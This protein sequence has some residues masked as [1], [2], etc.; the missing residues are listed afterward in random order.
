[1][2]KKKEDKAKKVAKDIV[3]GIGMAYIAGATGEHFD[4]TRTILSNPIAGLTAMSIQGRR[5]DLEKR[6]QDLM[7]KADAMEKAV[8]SEHNEEVLS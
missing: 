3:Q 5:E 7:A 6:T 4:F 8:E 1:M 2:A